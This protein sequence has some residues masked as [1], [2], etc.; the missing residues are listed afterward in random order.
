MWRQFIKGMAIA[1][2]TYAVTA[3][4]GMTIGYF[5]HFVR[6]GVEM[7]DRGDYEPGKFREY[8]V[9]EMNEDME[10]GMMSVWP[11]IKCKIFG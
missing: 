6:E 3:G 11:Y 10:V 2:G 8:W 5:G 4:V 9:K 1:A 7:M